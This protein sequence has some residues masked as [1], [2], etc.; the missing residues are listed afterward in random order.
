M[1]D[2]IFDMF[3]NQ[4]QKKGINS[5][6]DVD[7]IVEVWKEAGFI[8]EVDEKDV[9]NLALSYDSALRYVINNELNP[10]LQNI[11]F[12]LTRRI[13]L[14]TNVNKPI[15]S[16]IVC[17]ILKKTP[18]SLF[19]KYVKTNSN[20]ET[21]Q[22]KI[23]EGM[24]KICTE[25]NLMDKTLNELDYSIFFDLKTELW[26]N[27]IDAEAELT[28]LIAKYIIYQFFSKQTILTKLQVSKEE[29]VDR[30]TKFGFILNSYDDNKKLT[31]AQSYE[32]MAYT[33]LTDERFNMI[34]N[35][36]G[37]FELVVFPIIARVVSMRHALNNNEAEPID[38]QKIISFFENTTIGDVFET[39]YPVINVDCSSSCIITDEESVSKCLADRLVA[40][41]CFNDLFK[42]IS[43]DMP[44]IKFNFNSV[45]KNIVKSYNLDIEAIFV[46]MISS[47]LYHKL[48]VEE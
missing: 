31:L 29:V 6:N 39:E 44:L 18:V 4:Y 2:F 8:G 28:N 19:I 3:K 10:F 43:K 38:P 40:K 34:Y 17:K 7:K 45:D 16:K 37:W 26:S 41:A 14:K 13:Y 21:A 1:M 48:Y 9:T 22:L 33:I 25:Q 36:R 32:N 24:E 15:E 23:C 30:W 5:D 46:A 47:L 27:N 11:I 12:P 35:E 20:E 42:I